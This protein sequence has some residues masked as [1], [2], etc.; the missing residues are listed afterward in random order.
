M[1]SGRVN[2]GVIGCGWISE[3]HLTSLSQLPEANVV[4]VSDI[5]EEKAR[6]TAIRFGVPKY[7]RDY[8]EMIEKEE[9]D[10][11]DVLVPTSLHAKVVIDCLEMGKHVIVEKPIAASVEE[12]KQ[13]IDV[14]KRSGKKFTVAH[15]YR[16]WPKFAKA[17]E[18]INRGDI[19]NV[20][21][22]MTNHRGW[23][24]WRGAWTRWTLKK[25]SGGPIVEVGIHPIDLVRWYLGKEIVRIYALAKRVHFGVEVPDLVYI[26]MEAED[27]SLGS[28]E[29]SRT[30]VPRPYPYYHFLQV[31]GDRGSIQVYDCYDADFII[32]NEQGISIREGRLIIPE[33]GYMQELQ[34]FLRC[35][36]E[37]KPP[38]VTAEDA[39]RAL[40]LAWKAVESAEKGKPVEVA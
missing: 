14:V 8:K 23:F 6:Q 16:F 2:V 7:Y 17:K 28:V 25:P 27:G 12:G 33:H 32:H 3:V 15:N 5:V 34:Y 35:V 11:V 22:V 4:A 18:V 36:I 20:N 13:I 26:T 31:E 24:W 21:F 1:S 38:L 29:V 19:G 40:E 39:T 37:D 30:I 10:I 9:I